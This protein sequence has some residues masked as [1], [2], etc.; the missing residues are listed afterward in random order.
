MRQLAQTMAELLFFCGADS[1]TSSFYRRESADR[2]GLYKSVCYTY[3]CTKKGGWIETAE[4]L[5]SHPNIRASELSV[6][7]SMA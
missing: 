4:L 6:L 2:L 7:D 3:V 1:A 5:H